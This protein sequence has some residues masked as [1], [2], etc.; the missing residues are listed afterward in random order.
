M[1]GWTVAVIFISSAFSF[2]RLKSKKKSQIGKISQIEDLNLFKISQIY[3][4]YR[5]LRFKFIL[6]I[7]CEYNESTNRLVESRSELLFCLFFVVFLCFGCDFEGKIFQFLIPTIRIVYYKGLIP[8]TVFRKVYAIRVSCSIS[9][10]ELTN[11]WL[12]RI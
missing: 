5:K 11:N 4:K 8:T 2:M 12:E 10:C 9:A 1:E 7:D 6:Y 3:S